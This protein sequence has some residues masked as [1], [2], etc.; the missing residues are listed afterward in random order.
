MDF[1]F[2]FGVTG[3][4]PEEARRLC[5]EA[6]ETAARLEPDHSSSQFT[7]AG[8]YLISGDREKF[9]VASDRFFSMGWRSNNLAGWLTQWNAYSGRW[10]LGV[11]LTE[12]AINL[13]P[14]HYPKG[15]H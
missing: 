6:A 1:W 5:L 2:S 9:W 3:A 15:W 13:S 14:G 4:A 12:K 8:A 11:A 7:L 10:D